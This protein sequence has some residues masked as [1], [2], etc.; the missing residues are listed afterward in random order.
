MLKIKSCGFLQTHNLGAYSGFPF[1]IYCLIAHS[2]QCVIKAFRNNSSK[3]I[4]H[5]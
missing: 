2:H 5:G 3:Y 4:I 1:S